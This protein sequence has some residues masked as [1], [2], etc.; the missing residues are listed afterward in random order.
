MRVRFSRVLFASFLAGSAL[1]TTA[2]AAFVTGFEPP[3]YASGPLSGQDSWSATSATTT[4]TARVLTAAE[5]SGELAVAGLNPAE[6]VHSGGQAVFVTGTAGSSSTF[7]PISGLETETRVLMDV[8]ARPLTPGSTGSTVGTAVG[9]TF[10]TMEDNTGDRAAAFRFGFVNGAATIDYGTA[11]QS[12]IWRPSGVVWQ[13][14]T[15]YQL[16]MDVNYTDK[17][18]DFFIDGTKVNPEPVPFYAAAS[19]NLA[20]VRIFR[21]SNQAG[22]IVDDLSVAVPEPAGLASLLLA[23][24]A[25]VLRR[26]ASRA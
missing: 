25:M 23:G 16:T 20:Q 18:Y 19:E 11:A 2:S 7:R 22:A 3:T 24:S 26:R 9:N 21:G 6:P 14:D 17:T 5:I 13:A 4:G 1:A 15:W 12:G 8:F 10:L